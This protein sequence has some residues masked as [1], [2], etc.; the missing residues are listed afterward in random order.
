[1]KMSSPKKDRKKMSQGKAEAESPEETL[2]LQK[3]RTN[4]NL[5]QGRIGAQANATQYD[6]E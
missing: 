1:M 6:R 5:S 2:N 4:V 3:T